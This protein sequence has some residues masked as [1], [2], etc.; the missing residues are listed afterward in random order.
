M[1]IY[2]SGIPRETAERAY[3]AYLLGKIPEDGVLTMA[4]STLQITACVSEEISAMEETFTLPGGETVHAELQADMAARVFQAYSE[5]RRLPAGLAVTVSREGCFLYK[6]KK[7]VEPEDRLTFP[8]ILGDVLTDK[9]IE[10]CCGI[11]LKKI[12]ADCE[13]GSFV[14]SEAKKTAGG[15]L[16]TRGAAETRYEQKK[17]WPPAISP[18]LLVYAT[19]EAAALWNRGAEEIRSAAAGGGHRAA[20]LGDGQR[21]RAGKLWLVT[22]EAVEMLFGNPVPEKWREFAASYG[23]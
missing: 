15:W 20:R 7:G 19:T 3:A 10:T 5:W 9:E 11:P 14:P 12:R 8:N 1:K 4:G 16:L 22:R 18:L 23:N 6:G 21:R 17:T 2:Y 13:A